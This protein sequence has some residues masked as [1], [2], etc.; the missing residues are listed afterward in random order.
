MKIGTMKIKNGEV[1]IRDLIKGFHE[2]EERGVW[3]YDGKLNIRPAYQREY[4]YKGAQKQAVIETI[5]KGY[6][7]GIFYWVAN[8]DCT[9]EVLDGQQRIM[10]IV[11]YVVGDQFSVDVDGAPFYFS[12][13]EEN[14]PEVCEK[15][16][17]HVLEIKFCSGGSFQEKLDWFEII[18]THGE[19]LTPQELRNGVYSGP[20]VTDA[21]RY[22]SKPNGAAIVKGGDYVS[23][24]IDRQGFLETGIKWIAGD[25]DEQIKDYMA[26]HRNKKDAK[27]LFKH[28]EA[29]ID[30]V[31]WIFPNYKDEMKGVDW[32]RLYREYHHVKG[33]DPAKLAERVDMLMAD[34][35]IDVKKGIYEYLLSGKKKHLNLR[36][37]SN[38]ERRVL[39]ERQ[40]GICPGCSDE[41]KIKEMDADHV[42]PWVEG[43]ATRLENAQM[44][45]RDCNRGKGA[46]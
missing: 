10:S 36:Q 1:E 8:E 16:L 9:Y 27:E 6:P 35:D 5:L 22:F 31:E 44:L 45:C 12:T 19:K 28:F 13:Y 43:G 21:K 46:R 2:S 40:K 26:K 14:H 37:F 33:F 11:R 15:I 24:V 20:W 42:K 34:E 7:L 3:G 41:F 23:A 38:A 17:G 39:Y 29:V 4:I 18:N 30:W 32:G 25:S